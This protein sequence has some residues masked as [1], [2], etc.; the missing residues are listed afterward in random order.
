MNLWITGRLKER[1]QIQKQSRLFREEFSRRSKQII[2]GGGDEGGGKRWKN[3]KNK[4][5][6]GGGG[7]GTGASG[8]AGQQ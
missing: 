2:D 3:K 7:D 4:Q 6:K 8:S 1:A 5:G